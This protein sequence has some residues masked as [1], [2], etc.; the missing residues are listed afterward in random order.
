MYNFDYPQQAIICRDHIKMQLLIVGP[1]CIH[2]PLNPRIYYFL[3]AW[4]TTNELSVFIFVANIIHL[5][6]VNSLSHLK[7][8]EHHMDH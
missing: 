1:G 3:R 2:Y 4:R 6:K 8:I 5:A 7:P